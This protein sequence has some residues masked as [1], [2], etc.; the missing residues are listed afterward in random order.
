MFL[1]NAK[2]FALSVYTTGR[3]N[4][5]QTVGVPDAAIAAIHGASDYHCLFGGLDDTALFGYLPTALVLNGLAIAERH[6][7][8]VGELANRTNVDTMSGSSHFLYLFSFLFCAFIITY[9]HAAVKRFFS[10][11]IIYFLAHE[12]ISG[13][14]HYYILPTIGAKKIVY[15]IIYYFFGVYSNL[16]YLTAKR[17]RQLPAFILNFVFDAPFEPIAEHCPDCRRIAHTVNYLC[18]SFAE[19]VITYCNHFFNDCD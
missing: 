16:S 12:R 11:K 8:I 1:A 7:V 15:Y 17:K 3:I 2:S 13:R 9:L 10:E 5:I 4:V 18:G 19:K 14:L 6:S